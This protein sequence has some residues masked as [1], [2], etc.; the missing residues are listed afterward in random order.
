MY[1]YV[2]I[3]DGRNKNSNSRISLFAYS[4][5]C[6]RFSRKWST[7]PMTTGTFFQPKKNTPPRHVGP[8]T[9]L[10]QPNHAVHSNS[11]SKARAHCT[12]LLAHV[13]VGVSIGMHQVPLQPSLIQN[14]ILNLQ[15][16]ISIQKISIF[17]LKKTPKSVLYLIHIKENNWC[18]KKMTM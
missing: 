7:Q 13:T 15:N 11:N 9:R 1:H 2:F 3:Y 8:P 10:S 18:Y 6:C 17:V 16:H 5:R 14:F 4:I 12:G